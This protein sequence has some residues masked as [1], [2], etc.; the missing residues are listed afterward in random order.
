MDR[1]IV[2]ESVSQT[3]FLVCTIFF[4]MTNKIFLYYP[5]PVRDCLFTLS[6]NFFIDMSN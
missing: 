5:A 3:L 4:S 1:H 6:S 2:G